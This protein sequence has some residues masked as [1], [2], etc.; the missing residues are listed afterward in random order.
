MIQVRY[1][2]PRQN[3]IGL[4]DVDETLIRQSG[5]THANNVGLSSLVIQRCRKD[6]TGFAQEV[7]VGYQFQFG[8]TTAERVFSRFYGR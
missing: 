3:S 4:H 8:L 1:G 6:R 5:D 2:G 7:V